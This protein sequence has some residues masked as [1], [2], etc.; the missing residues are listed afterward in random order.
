MWE[1]NY[2]ESW[3]PKNWCFWTVVLEKTLESPL[4]C[5]ETQSIHP[6][7]DQSWIFIGRTD[8]G[9]E[10]PI[11]WPPVAKN[12]FEKTLML[13]KIE[14]GRRRGQHSKRWLDGI[15]D[16]MDLSLSKLREFVLDREAWCAAVHGVAKSRT[17]LSDWTESVTFNGCSLQLFSYL[18]FWSLFWNAKTSGINFVFPFSL[19]LKPKGKIISSLKVRVLAGVEITGKNMWE[20]G[21]CQLMFKILSCH[22]YLLFFLTTASHVVLKLENI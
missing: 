4:D 15:T 6:Q 22:L 16:S 3:V 17:W 2:K 7:G 11:L 8:A 13:G 12:S 1:L 14:G 9:A 10:T 5:K 20:W 18:S 19:F 21:E